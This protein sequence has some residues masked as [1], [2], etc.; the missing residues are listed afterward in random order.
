MKH[1]GETILGEVTAFL[2]SLD[3][4]DR[5]GPAT[6]LYN[7]G[8]LLRLVLAAEARGIRCLPQPFE[9]G[10]RW[11]SEAL[12]YTPFAPRTRSDTL[13]ESVTHANGVSVIVKLGA[14]AAPVCTSRATPPSL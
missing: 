11:F 7:E 1:A 8:W 4:A 5:Q 6:L 10:A 3:T 13:G 12:L 9:P 2:S 14:A